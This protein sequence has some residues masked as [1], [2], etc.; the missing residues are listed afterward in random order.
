MIIPE[1]TDLDISHR[2]LPP[3]PAVPG[4]FTPFQGAAIWFSRVAKN[5][6]W[7]QVISAPS[8]IAASSRKYRLSLG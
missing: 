1:S 4:H 2:F 7:I 8:R 3:N 6:R 5:H